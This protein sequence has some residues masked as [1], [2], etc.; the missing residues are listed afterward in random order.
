MDF[1]KDPLS[2]FPENG[3]IFHAITNQ[4]YKGL[5]KCELK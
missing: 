2:T 4:D 1:W 5:R 3:V